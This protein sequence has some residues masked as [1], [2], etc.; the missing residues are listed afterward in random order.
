[1]RMGGREAIADRL[2]RSTAARGYDPHVDVDWSAPLV[3]GKA[4]LLPHRCSLYGTELY[5]RLSPE[6]RIELGKHEIVSVASAGIFLE[7]VLMRLLARHAYWGDPVSRHVQYALAELGEETRHTTMFARMIERLGT[8]CYLPPTAIRRLGGLLAATAHGPSL[9]GAILIG[10]EIVDRLQ[11]EQVGDESIQPLIRMISKIHIIE[12]SR[13]VSFARA[14][15]TR[16]VSKMPR[17]TIPYHRMVLARTAFVMSRILVSP[18]VYRSVGLDPRQ[19]RRAA[20][21]NPC[22]QETIRYG[23]EK[24]VAF[25]DDSGLIGHPGML[26]WRRSFLLG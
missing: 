24:I 10:E 17:L 25:L 7:G 2:L 3:D 20:L 9:W 16:S 6:Q 26:L 21:A 4:F 15:L 12:E 23:G 18:E 8:P 14:E 22:F 19:A 13:H 11:R 1:M 5:E